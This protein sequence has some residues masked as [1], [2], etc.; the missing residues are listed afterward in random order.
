MASCSRRAGAFAAGLVI[1]AAAVAAAPGAAAV[2]LEEALI[3][4]YN[5]NPTLRAQRAA[6][7]ATDEEV[8]EA[9]SGWRPT[10]TVTGEAGKSDVE[11][12]SAFFTSSVGSRAPRARRPEDRPGPAAATACR[13][14]RLP[15]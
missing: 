8:P 13:A 4:A 12:E 6:L 1:A 3:A 5:N 7:R 14:F 15:R 10:V 9:L 11:S 2:T